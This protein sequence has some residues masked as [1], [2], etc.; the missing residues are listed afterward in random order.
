MNKAFNSIASPYGLSYDDAA[1][2]VAAY[3]V[4]NWMIANQAANPQKLPYWLYVTRLRQV[5]LKTGLS[6]LMRATGLCWAKS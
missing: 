5:Y 2:I 1:D 4:V 3:E 6:M